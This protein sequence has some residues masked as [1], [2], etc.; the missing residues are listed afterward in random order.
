MRPNPSLLAAFLLLGSCQNDI[1][2]SDEIEKDNLTVSEEKPIQPP[3]SFQTPFV[4]LKIDPTRDTTVRLETGS[5]VDIPANAFVDSNGYPI[6]DGEVR[7]IFREFNDAL[8]IMLSGIPMRFEDKPF[9][10]AGM[11]ELKA[12]DGVQIAA[13]KKLNIKLASRSSDTDFDLYQF[14][15]SEGKWVKTGRDSVVLP[16][17]EVTPMDQAPMPVE[18]QIPEPMR[19]MEFDGNDERTI[20]IGIDEQSLLSDFPELTN[21]VENVNFR[22]LEESYFDPEDA[23][24]DWYYMEVDQEIDGIYLLTFYGMAD[25]GN[26]LVREYRA[27]PVYQGKDFEQKTKAYESALA[28]FKEDQARMAEERRKERDR[29]EQRMILNQKVL[30]VFEVEDF[31][32][33]N[34][35]RFYTQPGRIDVRGTLVYEDKSVEI[36]KYYIIDPNRTAV[37]SFFCG[38]CSQLELSLVPERQYMIWAQTENSELFVSGRFSRTTDQ[39]QKDGA[40]EIPVRLQDVEG[41]DYSS[42]MRGIR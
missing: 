11:C 14:N 41:L 19:P 16:N 12:R 20:K 27:R 35:D 38:A 10:S 18:S 29:F 36:V 39:L 21:L 40:I 4:Q 33:Y 25:N 15:E 7:L 30:R 23:Q 26:K 3:L 24:R 22:I 31:G 42:L 13:G 9:E 32:I 1:D 37:L 5:S 8:D 28:E 34:C 6:S 17:S 2:I